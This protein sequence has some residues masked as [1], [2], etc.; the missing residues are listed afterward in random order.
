MKYIKRRWTN[1]LSLTPAYQ[2]LVLGNC[3]SN[4]SNISLL[5]YFAFYNTLLYKKGVVNNMSEILVTRRSSRRNGETVHTLVTEEIYTNTT[6]TVPDNLANSIISVRIF[7]AGGGGSVWGGG[8]SGWMNNTTVSLAIGTPVYISIGAGGKCGYATFTTTGSNSPQFSTSTV[9]GNGGTTSF[10]SYLSAPGGTGSNMTRAGSGGSGGGSVLTN[11]GIGYQFGGGGCYYD[12]SIAGYNKHNGGD[13][14]MWGGGG[15]GIYCGGNGGTYGG[16]GGAYFW[17]GGRGG[18]YG[19][20]GGSKTNG[21]HGI[22]GTYGGNGGSPNTAA[23]NG[24]NT[25]T[26]T[27]ILYDD[28][29][30]TTLKGNGECGYGNVVGGGGFG[31]YT[32]DDRY[33]P[34]GGGGGGGYG[35]KGGGWAFYG[36][37]TPFGKT[38]GCGGGGFGG[39]GGSDGGGGGGY[40]WR[41]S[42]GYKGGGGGGYYTL[43]GWN[44]GGGGGYGPIKLTD[45]ESHKSGN[46]LTYNNAFAPYASGGGGINVL[47]YHQATT[48]W[49]ACGG[50][51]ICVI[52]YYVS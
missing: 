17:N 3:F 8:G 42:G 12:T 52:Q 39:S 37:G 9:G 10:G 38:G 45:T 23:Q 22:G 34:N 25:S 26:W 13:G 1:L 21:R 19:G 43:G 20:G 14:G 31:G 2:D 36:N 27:N 50:N 35:G 32:G 40:G 30:S 46:L 49:A 7:G 51:G 6:W 16:G 28:R 18:T 15:Y 4:E 47:G 24:T 41:G 11:G 48:Y 5:Y 29:N 44:T 33:N